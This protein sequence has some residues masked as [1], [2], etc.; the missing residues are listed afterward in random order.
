MIIV[1]LW[2]KTKKQC[3]KCCFSFL[4]SDNSAS[5]YWYHTRWS[6]GRYSNITGHISVTQWFKSMELHCHATFITEWGIRSIDLNAVTF[7]LQKCNWDH[8][9]A[10]S[11]NKYFATL[12]G[13]VSGSL[14]FY[15]Q[16]FMKLFCNYGFDV[17]FP[18]QW[19]LLVLN[20][21]VLVQNYGPD[22]LKKLTAIVMIQCLIFF[23]AL[24]ISCSSCGVFT[25]RKLTPQHL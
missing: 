19:L 24:S 20:D 5:Y 12:C 2:G 7:H 8:N 18:M 17:K 9:Q 3:Q 11:I 10:Y 14:L 15:W 22:T 21:N 13:K 1:C 23:P 4:M 16:F 6:L 25:E